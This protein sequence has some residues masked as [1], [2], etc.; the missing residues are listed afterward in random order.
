M[1][2]TRLAVFDMDGTLMDSQDFIVQAM[3]GAFARYSLPAPAR[4]DILSIVG[5]SLF[6]AVARLIP[7]HPDDL[8]LQVSE[9]Y[10]ACFIAQRAQTGG[11]ASAPLYPGAR[12]VIEA[13]AARRGVLLG[14]ATGK[15]RRGLDHAFA[16]HGLDPFFST[17]QTADHHP[18][19]PHPSMVLSCLNETGA[20]KSDT[21]MI[22]D[23]TFDIEMGRA[24]G[25]HT[26]G[27]TWGYH[28]TDDLRAAGA[29]LLVDGFDAVLS[30]LDELWERT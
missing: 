13:L 7:D 30:A 9:A 8:I 10:K 20:D 18:S 27:V 2:G 3:E 15:A 11:E 17:R 26:L 29:D 4:A 23:T 12:A 16:A 1:S 25:V 21:V 14:V 22:G 24:A 6:E 5:L 19:K 28:P